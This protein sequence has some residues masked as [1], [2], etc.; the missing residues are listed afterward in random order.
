MPPQ[1][2]A[3]FLDTMHAGHYRVYN[4]CSERHYDELMFHKRVER[5]LIDDHNVPPLA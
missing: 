1:E 5:H 2:V 3:R 4:L